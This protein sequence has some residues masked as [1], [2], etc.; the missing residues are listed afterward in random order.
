M[1]CVV[2]VP[3][4]VASPFV[5]AV[6]GAGAPGVQMVATPA[7]EELHVVPLTLATGMILVKFS[8]RPLVPLVPSAINCA[9]CPTTATESVLGV[10]ESAM[11]GSALPP[12][13]PQLTAQAATATVAPPPTVPPNPGALAPTWVVPTPTARNSP[14]QTPFTGTAQ[15][16]A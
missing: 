1:I 3:V 11:I 5:V 2:P 4:A 6:Q 7:F 14:E 13:P 15:L 8:C 16:G 9:V 12:P 10:I